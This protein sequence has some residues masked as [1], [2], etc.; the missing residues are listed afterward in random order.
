VV[1]VLLANMKEKDQ[2]GEGGYQQSKK[3][4]GH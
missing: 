3:M 4:E 1:L 2:F